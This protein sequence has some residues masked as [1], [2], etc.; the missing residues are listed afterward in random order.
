M[1]RPAV[2]G[3]TALMGRIIPEKYIDASIVI[4]FAL[5]GIAMDITLAL[6][7]LP[8]EKKEVDTQV[9]MSIDPSHL[10]PVE[11]H[12]KSPLPTED[13][14]T[15]ESLPPTPTGDVKRKRKPRLPVVLTY[16]E[17]AFDKDRRLLPDDEVPDMA[18]E[19]CQAIRTYLRSFVYQGKPVI[20]KVG[21]VYQSY[22]DKT[23]LIKFIKLQ[24]NT[25]QSA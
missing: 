23:N 21:R 7:S 14:P 11:Y 3:A 6:S 19:K 15:V 17:A 16:I 22:F 5:I 20:K 4:L 18:K 10:F 9:E 8:E 13:A 25:Q 12:F 2:I 1:I 24:Y